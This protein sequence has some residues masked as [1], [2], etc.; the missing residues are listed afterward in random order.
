MFSNQIA[1]TTLSHL[2][3]SFMDGPPVNDRPL[4]TAAAASPLVKVSVDGVQA[5]ACG[6]AAILRVLGESYGTLDTITGREGEYMRRERKR[7]KRDRE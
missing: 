3:K 1:A 4:H 5:T 2:D 7:E 6:G